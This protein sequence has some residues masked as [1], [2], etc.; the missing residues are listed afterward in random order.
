VFV[1][2]N[3]GRIALRLDNV[4]TRAE[5]EP[6]LRSLPVIGPAPA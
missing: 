6:Y 3:D 1:I 5:I 2:G 4:A